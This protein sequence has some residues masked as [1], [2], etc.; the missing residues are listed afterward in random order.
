MIFERNSL[1]EKMGEKAGFIT[2]Y[3]LFTTVL[4]FILT[5]LNKIHSSWSYFHIMGITIII[6]IIGILVARFLK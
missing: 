5:F 6:S 4:F 1:I 3:L 2:A